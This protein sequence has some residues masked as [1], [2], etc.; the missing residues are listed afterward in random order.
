[1]NKATAERE[2]AVAELRAAIKPGDTVYTILRHVSRSGM[3]R[4]IDVVTMKNN[5]PRPWSYTVAKAMG[6][7]LD[8]DGALKVG[9][10]GMDMGFHIVHSLGYALFGEEAEKGNTRAATALRKAILKADPHYLTQMGAVAPDPSLPH[11]DWFG[12][13]GYALK[14]RWL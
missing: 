12:A 8:K 5:E 2:E 14:H 3:Q 9:G 7:N 1:M 13:A 4:S 10:C 6:Y 11:R